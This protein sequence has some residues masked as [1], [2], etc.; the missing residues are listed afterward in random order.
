[1]TAGQISR[2]TRGPLASHVSRTCR[3][4]RT[5]RKERQRGQITLI[6][7]ALMIGLVG[8]VGLG[9]DGGMAYMTKARLNAA[10]DS[11]AVAAARA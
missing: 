5:C 1:M 9:I 4:C 3:T 8:V 7:A 6:A 11:A 2:L 10:V